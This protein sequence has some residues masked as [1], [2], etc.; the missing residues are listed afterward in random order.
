MS[1][2]ATP[3][4]PV[5]AGHGLRLTGPHWTFILELYQGPEVQ[6]ACLLLQDS[7]GVD[8]S[9]L[10]TM[11]SFAGAGYAFAP[12]DIEALDH[13]TAPWRRDVVQ[14]LRAIRRETRPA[15][16]K[17]AAISGFRDRIKSAEIEAE[18][19]EIAILAQAIAALK[20]AGPAAARASAAVVADTAEMV[21]AFY[22]GRAAAA[23]GHVRLGDFSGPIGVVTDAV[24]RAITP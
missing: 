16:A 23:D 15:A 22:A 9:F 10:L 8:V 13:Q 14:R 19:I 7:F 6:Q 1:G 24:V 17:D 2:A 18:Q 3:P 21:V 12:S 5:A 4:D 11:L 20:S